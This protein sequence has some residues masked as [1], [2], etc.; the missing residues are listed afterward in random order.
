[1]KIIRQIKFTGKNL[2]DVFNLPC[3]KSVLKIDKQPVFELWR[4]Y[5]VSQGLS[6]ICKIGD[7]LVEYDNHRWEIK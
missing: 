6:R 1:M 3:V 7:T 4:F 5:L 2:N